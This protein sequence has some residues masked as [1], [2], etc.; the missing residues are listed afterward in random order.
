[1][2]FNQLFKLKQLTLLSKE[3]KL[4]EKDFQ[5]ITKNLSKDADIFGE[6]CCVWKGALCNNN[7]KEKGQYINIYH[8]NTKKKNT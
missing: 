2:K 5:F 1:M 8:S 3:Q 4:E 7:K 6:K